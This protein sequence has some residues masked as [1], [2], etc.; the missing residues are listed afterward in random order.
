[1]IGV[2]LLGHGRK[3]FPGSLP[4]E[5]ADVV[6]DPQ[7]GKDGGKKDGQED[8]EE[9]YGRVIDADLGDH[10]VP[11]VEKEDPGQDD[12]NSMKGAF[13]RNPGSVAGQCS[14][15]VAMTDT[16]DYN[17]M[18]FSTRSS[19]QRNG[20]STVYICKSCSCIGNLSHFKIVFNFAK[21]V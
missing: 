16:P 15:P 4:S 12:D 10:L 8:H 9:G 14:L 19:S 13:D 18:M 7:E 21:N 11:P 5:N 20:L 1:M 6:P 2:T 17:H 3:G